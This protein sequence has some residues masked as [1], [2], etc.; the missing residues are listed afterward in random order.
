[1]NQLSQV[2]RL[3]LFAAQARFGARNFGQL[4]EYPQQVVDL[5]HGAGSINFA[6]FRGALRRGQKFNPLAQARQR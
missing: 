2:Q 3:E 4:R 1:M 6:L 5:A